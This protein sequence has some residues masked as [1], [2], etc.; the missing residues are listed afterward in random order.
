MKSVD[1]SR[2]FGCG[3]DN[4]LGLQ[5]IKKYVGDKARI[6]FTVKPE[7]TGYPGLMHGGITC[8]LFDEVM[9]HAIA[10]KG[11]IAVIAKMTVDYRSPA[12]VGDILLCEAWILKHEG[13][14]LDISASIINGRTGALVAEGKGLFIEVDIDKLLVGNPQSGYLA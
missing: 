8:V 7:Y 1:L 9:Y 5:L 14:K 3:A 6:E 2:C 4:P 11:I 12:V 13:R 10:R